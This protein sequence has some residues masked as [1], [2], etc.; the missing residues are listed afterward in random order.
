MKQ[1]KIY[2]ASSWRNV[3]YSDVITF[4]KTHPEFDIYDFQHPAQGNNGFSWSYIDKNWEYWSF[5]SYRKALE[6]P[7][8]ERGF[9]FDFNAMQEA[10]ACVL[11]LPCGRSAHIEAGFMAGTKKPVYALFRDNQEPE[12]MYKCLAGVSNNLLE[13]AGKLLAQQKLL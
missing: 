10:H 5:A 2:V 6:H 7:I 11:V 12:L 4:L 8:A 1:L 9:A 3:W 13:I